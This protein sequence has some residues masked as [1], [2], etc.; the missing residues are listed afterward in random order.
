MRKR[1]LH[2]SATDPY[3]QSPR[4]GMRL[5]KHALRA[6]LI[7]NLGSKPGEIAPALHPLRARFLL[8]KTLTKA[9][10][11][12]VVRCTD[13][14]C[15]ANS[16]SFLNNPLSKTR[17]TT[18]GRLNQSLNRPEP[19]LM[20]VPYL[21]FL[22]RCYSGPYMVQYAVGVNLAPICNRSRFVYSTISY[23]CSCSPLPS[24]CEPSS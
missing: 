13:P 21:G 19:M 16:G 8:G 20:E 17:Q 12:S 9:L 18:G 11:Y 1:R 24:P 10:T 5:F 3:A 2:L 22:F 4:S 23:K 15:V 7:R 6:G 14:I